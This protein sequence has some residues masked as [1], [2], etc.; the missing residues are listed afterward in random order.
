MFIGAMQAQSSHGASVLAPPLDLSGVTEFVDI[1]GGS[2][3]LC[4]EV[5]RANTV[6][7]LA[8]VAHMVDQYTEREGMADAVRSVMG[9]MFG[10]DVFHPATAT[11]LATPSTTGTTRRMR[12]SSRRPTGPSRNRGARS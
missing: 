7:E 3:T 6:Y 5:C 2:G 9:D 4:R 11:R 8:E 12:T 1:A 10:D